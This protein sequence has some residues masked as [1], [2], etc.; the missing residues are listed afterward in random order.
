MTASRRS[1]PRSRRSVARLAAV[2][3]LYEMDLAGSGCDA[4]LQEFVATRWR[5]VRDQGPIPSPDVALLAKLT[6]GV[7]SRQAEV[8]RL[9]VQSLAADL[10]LDRLEVVLRAI[11]RA[12]TWELMAAYDVP[13]RVVINEYVDVSHA[14]FEGKETALVNAVLDR[15]AHRLRPAETGSGAGDRA[16]P[17][18]G[19]RE[20]RDGT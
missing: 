11:L 6:R 13:A 10:A 7:A 2:Q 19:D 14:F 12:G 5:H 3:A 18:T 8:D 20:D 16:A 4:V 15:L 9:I 1:G 17:D